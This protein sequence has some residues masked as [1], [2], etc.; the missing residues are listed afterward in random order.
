V[1]CALGAVVTRAGW[2]LRPL[3]VRLE[4][5]RCAR[6]GMTADNE[7]RQHCGNSLAWGGNEFNAL[8]IEY[9][10]DLPDTPAPEDLTPYLTAAAIIEAQYC[11]AAV[12]P[13]YPNG[14]LVENS[15][16]IARA[17][18]LRDAAKGLS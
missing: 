18:A 4:A 17:R 15:Y 1:L 13:N 9:A 12:S 6:E 3:A 16:V 8:E 10:L 2:A 5:C 11:R 7:Q 14:P